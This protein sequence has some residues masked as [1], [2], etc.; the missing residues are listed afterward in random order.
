MKIRG[1]L[2]AKGRKACL[3]EGQQAEKVETKD[4]KCKVLSELN[5][6]LLGHIWALETMANSMR[7][8][9]LN[10]KGWR[11]IGGFGCYGRESLLI[12]MP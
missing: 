6:N 8:K 9:D 3:L 4:L 12:K 5:V 7:K 10:R 11:E 2:E 1:R